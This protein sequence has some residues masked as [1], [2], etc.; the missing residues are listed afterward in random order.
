MGETGTKV[1]GT[2]PPT[3]A[4][5]AGAGSIQTANGEDE[6]RLSTSTS[7]GTKRHS[8][9]PTGHTNIKMAA[10]EQQAATEPVCRKAWLQVLT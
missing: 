5:S 10:D 8:G 6:E 4:P 1:S 9:E 3:R 2:D 7:Q